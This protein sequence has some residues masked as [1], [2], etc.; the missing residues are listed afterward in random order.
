MMLT[1]AER[2]KQR[3]AE[4]KVMVR[5]DAQQ[6]WQAF[7]QHEPASRP[8]QKKAGG[9]SLLSVRLGAVAPKTPEDTID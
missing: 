8:P 5:S 9:H 2:F 6:S 1:L 4:L 3:L 7:S